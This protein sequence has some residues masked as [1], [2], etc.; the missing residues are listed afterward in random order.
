MNPS[1]Y[2]N[3]S[4]FSNRFLILGHTHISFID[5]SFN[6]NGEEMVMINPGSVDQPRDKDPRASYAIVDLETFST[7]IV[8]IDYD[9]DEVYKR[10]IQSGLPKSLGE[11]LYE[12]S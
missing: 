11:R 1:Q 12:G 6:E 8:R 3:N 9:I 2:D 5:K 7:E 4:V 10:I